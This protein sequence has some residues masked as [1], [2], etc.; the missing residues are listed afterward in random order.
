MFAFF[1]VGCS[2]GDNSAKGDNS[3]KE[4]NSVKGF[5]IST[6]GDSII[7]FTP[8]KAVL[9]LSNESHKKFTMDYEPID[10]SNYRLKSEE[11]KNTL[12]FSIDKASATLKID[13]PEND[14]ASKSKYL[15]AP[16]VTAK[17]IVGKWYEK[18]QDGDEENIYI[19]T[20]KEGSY[21]YETITLNH[22]KKTFKKEIEKN[23]QFRIDN[24]FIFVDLDSDGK[25]K[26]GD[27]Y[28]Y[29]LASYTKDTM[30]FTDSDGYKW[31]EQRL[32]N[33]S[34]VAIPEGYVL[35]K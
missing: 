6:K 28:V 15:K 23:I 24:G 25:P 7:E 35:A 33:P 2:G 30:N 12:I 16:S 8:S 21:D 19:I 29:Y 9:T 32:Q 5:W 11:T 18:D 13:S 4:D 17:D 10:A 22:T 20:Q 31:S 1:M 3:L 26:A 27:N 34:D 14:D